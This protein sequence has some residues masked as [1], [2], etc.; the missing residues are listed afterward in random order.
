MDEF[1]ISSKYAAHFSIPISQI[2]GFLFY[3][4]GQIKKFE[5]TSVDIFLSWV[6]AICHVT[7]VSFL[8]TLLHLFW[9][10]SYKSRPEERKPLLGVMWPTQ[11]RHN[12]SRESIHT[13]AVPHNTGGSRLVSGLAAGWHLVAGGIEDPLHEHDGRQSQRAAAVN[14][15]SKRKRRLRPEG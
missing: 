7:A 6:Q 2:W 14:R 8:L 12:L 5:D 11:H 10:L 3:I 4:F 9:S 13:A 15:R 1:I